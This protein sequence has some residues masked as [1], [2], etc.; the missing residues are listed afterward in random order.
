MIPIEARRKFMLKGKAWQRGG[1][2]PL[3]GLTKPQLKSEL[4][5]HESNAPLLTMTKLELEKEFHTL[6]KGITNFPALLTSKPQVDL[7][8]QNL[9]HYEVSTCEPLHDFKG[10]M[11]NLV[12]NRVKVRAHNIWRRGS[13]HGRYVRA[14]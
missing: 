6:R 3:A 5:A 12:R 4:Q 7:V 2:K 14:R 11:A 1:I 10:H 13:D 9:D 8:D